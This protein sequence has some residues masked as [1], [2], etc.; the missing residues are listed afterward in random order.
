[1]EGTG[2]LDGL[3]ACI[4]HFSRPHSFALTLV[5]Q[6]LPSSTPAGLGADLQVRLPA[7]WAANGTNGGG[8]DGTASLELPHEILELLEPPRGSSC[9]GDVPPLGYP[10]QPLPPSQRP[11]PCFSPPRRH[12]PV[13]PPLRTGSSSRAV[14]AA[15]NFSV[16]TPPEPL[17]SRRPGLMPPSP[18]VTRSIL[19]LGGSP[20]PGSPQRR[21][22]ASPHLQPLSPGV[23]AAASSL[24]AVAATAANSSGSLLSEVDGGA[25]DVPPEEDE[26][27]DL[28]GQ[29]NRG[30]V[31]GGG[32]VE[33]G[34]GNAAWVAGPNTTLGRAIAASA[35]YHALPGIAS[36]GS[37]GGPGLSYAQSAH[38]LLRSPGQPPGNLAEAGGDG[39]GR[40][41]E[42]IHDE[43][44]G[45]LS[46]LALGGAALTADRRVDRLNG[47]SAASAATR[48]GPLEPPTRSPPSRAGAPSRSSWR[49]APGER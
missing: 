33:Q 38:P 45:V 43:I 22:M 7:R 14:L 3:G 26:A 28:A 2:C 9:S 13:L 32:D 44:D 19:G 48:H 30:A 18:V 46:A 40:R 29:L 8:G 5:Q 49:I 39:M 17:F 21:W 42:T 1:M 6:L 10:L 37:S 23:R 16:L 36:L 15:P 20:L 11:P 34:G 31:S 35:S 4:V 47:A 24:C 25:C 27:L 12:M 41:D